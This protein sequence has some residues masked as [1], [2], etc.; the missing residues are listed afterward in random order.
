[1]IPRISAITRFDRVPVPHTNEATYALDAEGKEWIAK[2]EA[3]MGCESLLAE[4]LGWLL[5]R[6]LGV[7]IPDAA[8]CDDP[9][10]RAWLSRRV[11]DAGHWTAAAARKL[12]NPQEAAAIITLDAILFNEARHGRNLLLTGMGPD[13]R[14]SLWAIDADEALVGHVGE[15]KA[16]DGAVPDPRIHAAGFPA[17]RLREDALAAARLATTIARAELGAMVDAAC[18]VARELRSTELLHALAHRCTH[19][20]ELTSEYLH[21]LEQRT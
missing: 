16:L 17:A 11:P 18:D 9:G 14:L 4:A 12:A 21:R 5:A 2:R 20:A 10:E 1:M 6:R 15:Y 7:R 19:A 13:S 8:F 3:D